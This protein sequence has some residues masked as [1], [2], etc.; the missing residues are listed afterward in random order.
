MAV[1]ELI[2]EIRHHSEIIGEPIE[3]LGDGIDITRRTTAIFGRAGSAACDT[4]G[5]ATTL[6]AWLNGF[7]PHVVLPPVAKVIDIGK[8]FAFS[9]PELAQ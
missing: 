8:A 6:I 4:A 7:D 2:G 3:R 5:N 9:Q 1:D